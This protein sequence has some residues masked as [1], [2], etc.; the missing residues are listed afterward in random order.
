MDDVI[1]LFLES[2]LIDR[3]LLHIPEKKVIQLKTLNE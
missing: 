2:D 3:V 1:E